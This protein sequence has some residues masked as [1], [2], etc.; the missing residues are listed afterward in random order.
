[1]DNSSLTGEGRPLRKS[2]M[3]TS[4]NPLE[5]ENLAFF[6]TSV[7]EGSATGIVVTIGD[8][9]VMGRIA[10]LAE[11]IEGE[12]TPLSRDLT[13]FIRFMTWV[14][15]GIGVIFFIIAMVNGFSWHEALIFLIGTLVANV[16]EGSKLVGCK[17]GWVV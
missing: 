15:F 1:M 8:D 5:T 2:P 14:S 11:S 6:S 7:V 10:E 12:E 17:D 16:P 13:Y 3:C 4:M 9:T